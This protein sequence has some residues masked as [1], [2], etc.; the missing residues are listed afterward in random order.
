MLLTRQS[1]KIIFPITL[2]FFIMLIVSPV[3]AIPITWNLG[4]ITQTNENT[5]AYAYG[6]FVYDS[7]TKDILTWDISAY[8]Q[9]LSLYF[10]NESF[11]NPFKF[12]PSSGN[13]KANIIPGYENT[14]TLLFQ[15]KYT[16]TMFGDVQYDLMLESRGNGFTDALGYPQANSVLAIPVVLYSVTITGISTGVGTDIG[17]GILYS[18]GAPVPEPNTLFLLSVGLLGILIFKAKVNWHRKGWQ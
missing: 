1:P 10:P 17:T 16:G 18:R 5:I 12:T 3:M 13:A 14:P 9:Y 4:A 6:S 11:Q 15:S 2:T 8:S 7:S